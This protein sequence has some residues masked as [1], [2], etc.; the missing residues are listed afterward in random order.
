[1]GGFGS[2]VCR[3]IFRTMFGSFDEK[4]IPGKTF[5]FFAQPCIV[6]GIGIRVFYPA[7]SFR[8][9]GFSAACCSCKGGGKCGEV[10]G[11]ICCYVR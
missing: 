2:L 10:Y 5:V 4:E 11:G 8:V 6:M 3:D 1:M 9:S 7:S